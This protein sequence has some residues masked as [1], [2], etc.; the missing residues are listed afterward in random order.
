LLK[1]SFKDNDFLLSW[2]FN[3]P[4]QTILL[5]QRFKNKKIDNKS[6]KG[7]FITFLPESWCS[8]MSVLPFVP[9]TWAK[10]WNERRAAA[11]VQ[12]VATCER[13]EM[14]LS[15]S[16]A[17]RN[18]LPTFCAPYDAHALSWCAD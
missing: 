16:D 5:K 9:S 12:L 18:R 8:Q 13:V 17:S 14:F 4:K 10:R 2:A 15:S 1:L 11:A 6:K 7:I 3:H